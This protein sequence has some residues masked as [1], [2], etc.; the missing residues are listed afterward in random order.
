M[1]ENKDLELIK[2]MILDNLSPIQEKLQQL[3]EVQKQTDYPVKNTLAAS[4]SQDEKR[5]VRLQAY[6]TL[7]DKSVGREKRNAKVLF[8]KAG[9]T[10]T[11]GSQTTKITLPI[12]WVR[13]LGITEDDR[14]VDITMDVEGERII[15]E[16]KVKNKEVDDAEKS[17]EE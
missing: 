1:L 16:K 7:L 3:E 14:E 12:K 9:G 11:K 13:K 5:N 8:S 6:G 10:A 17:S 4:K 2:E 15:I